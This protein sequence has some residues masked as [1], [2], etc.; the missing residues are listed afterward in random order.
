MGLGAYL[1]ATTERN[2]YIAEE[3]RERREIVDDPAT[4][5]EEVYSV[6]SMYGLD[7]ELVRPVVEKLV[8]NE[9]MWIKVRW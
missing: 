4:E 2:Q 1:A 5:R 9:D 3:R 8:E 6:F 7:R